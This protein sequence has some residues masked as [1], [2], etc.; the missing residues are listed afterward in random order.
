MKQFY[1]SERLFAGKT[2][3]AH[4]NLLLD[5]Q[6]IEK[7]C[8]GAIENAKMYFQNIQAQFKVSHYLKSSLYHYVNIIL[9][10]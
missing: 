7:E 1:G 9:S 8:N 2:I 3:E 5:F 4:E 6:T 10:I